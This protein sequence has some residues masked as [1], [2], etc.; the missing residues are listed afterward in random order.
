MTFSE[1]WQNT[2]GEQHNQFSDKMRVWLGCYTDEVIHRV[3]LRMDEIVNDPLTMKLI[4]ELYV[5]TK[6]VEKRAVSEWRYELMRLAADE[7]KYENDGLFHLYPQ[8]HPESYRDVLYDL[9]IRDDKERE[10]A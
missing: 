9:Y 6:E 4:N 5:R 10:E 2:N 7:E 3:L 8:E 1:Y